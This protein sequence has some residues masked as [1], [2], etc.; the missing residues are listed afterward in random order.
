MFR[1]GF[2]GWKLAARLGVPLSL[3]IHVHYDDEAKSYWANSPDLDGL[4][5]A[6]S[7]LDELRDEVRGAVELLLEMTLD[8]HAPPARPDFRFKDAAIVAA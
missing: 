8:G 3:R 2:P 5:S 4:V 6:G 1:V 7:T